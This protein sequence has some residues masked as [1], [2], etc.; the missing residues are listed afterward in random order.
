MHILDKYLMESILDE[1]SSRDQNCID[2][3]KNFR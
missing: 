3:K 2:I 1:K